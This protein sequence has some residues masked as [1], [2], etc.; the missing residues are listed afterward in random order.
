M[1][2]RLTI[3]QDGV[4]FRAMISKRDDQGNGT[5]GAPEI[6][7]VDNKEE[8]KKRAKEMARGL[9]LKTYRVVD[10]TLKV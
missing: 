1:I 2:V 6:F 7:L 3:Q 5:I 4:G 9:G 10:R 8:A